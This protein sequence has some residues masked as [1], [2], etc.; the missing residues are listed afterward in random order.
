MS[1]PSLLPPLQLVSK[2]GVLTLVPN[3]KQG[4][5]DFCKAHGKLR[6]E[7]LGYHIAGNERYYSDHA[8]DGPFL[9]GSSGCSTC[10]ARSFP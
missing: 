8:A 9:N 1:S 6:N 7:Y 4:K 3:T 2:E 10:L 5:I